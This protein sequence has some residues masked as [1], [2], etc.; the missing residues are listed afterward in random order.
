MDRYFD[1]IDMLYFHQLQGANNN[2]ELSP[3]HSAETQPYQVHPFPT[4]PESLPSLPSLPESLPPPEGAPVQEFVPFE[5]LAASDARDFNAVQDLDIL[6][7]TNEPTNSALGD[8][9][10]HLVLPPATKEVGT[11]TD[12]ESHACLMC[13]G[14]LE[15]LRIALDMIR[16]QHVLM[17]SDH[18]E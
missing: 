12:E 8:A 5:A 10:P 13:Q 2:Q 1:H 4:P 9:A 14:Y 15:Q 7:R 17:T 18:H 6:T 11:Q 16:T 3:S